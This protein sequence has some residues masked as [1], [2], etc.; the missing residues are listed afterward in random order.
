[1]ETNAL[2]LS[3][4]LANQYVTNRINMVDG[5]E[6]PHTSTSGGMSGAIPEEV[7]RGRFRNFSV[8]NININIQS[9][10]KK[11]IERWEGKTIPTKE[12]SQYLE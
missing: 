5:K 1:M 12:A 6:G 9:R 8:Q 2:L 3:L 4:H 7:K 11:E 10:N